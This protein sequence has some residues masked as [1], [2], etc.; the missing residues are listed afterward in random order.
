MQIIKIF[1]ASHDLPTIKSYRQSTVE[2]LISALKTKANVHLFWFVYQ[3]EKSAMSAESSNVKIL[4]IHDYDNAVKVLND[5][6][7]D[8]VLGGATWDLIDYAFSLASK[9]LGIPVICQINKEFNYLQENFSTKLKSHVTRFFESSVPTDTQENEKKFMKRGRFFLFKYLFLLKTQIGIKMSFDKIIF[10]FFDLLKKNLVMEGDYDSRFAGTLHFL[11]SESLAQSLLNAGFDSS[12]LVVTGNPMYDIAFQRI[13]NSFSTKKKDNKIRVLLAPTSL[14]EHGFWTREQR[15]TAMTQ[16]VSQIE[17]H[18]DKLSLIVKI[19]PSTANFSEYQSLIH[20][21]NK[22]IPIYQKEDIIDILPDSD[23]VI[24]FGYTFAGMYAL[25]CKKPIIVCNFFDS[26]SDES[27]SQGVAFE[28]KESSSLIP[29]I[30][31]LS[32]PVPVYEK[33]RDKYINEFFYKDDGKASERICNEILQ[34]LNK[35]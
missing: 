15:D 16:I 28:C 24:T 32:Y 11:Q 7:P 5:V 33:N 23:V 13:K 6:K 31:K 27:V 29:L 26:V 19:H 9:R 18:S 22:S 20:S 30:E 14:Y 34:L 2:S 3:P 25:V 21:I 17:K 35:K 8:L 1:A 4:D 12:S 10:D